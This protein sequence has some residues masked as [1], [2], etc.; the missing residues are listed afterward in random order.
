MKKL[1]IGLATGF[2]LINMVGI[3]SAIPVSLVEQGSEWNYTT[4]SDDLWGP[5]GASWSSV[6]YSSFDWDSTSASWDTGLAAFGNK[7]IYGGLTKNTFWQARTDLA[8][9]QSFIVDIAL[10]GDV[11]LNVASDNGF[12]IFINGTQVAK[13]NA[14]G[15]TSYWEYTYTASSI[16]NLLQAGEN[17]IQVLAEDHGGV[18]FFDLQLTTEFTPVPEPATM[19][20]FGIG[21]AGLAST[22]LRKKK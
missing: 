3:A 5:G 12:A 2:F 10:I 11:T 8:L 16:S 4:L 20:L 7:D 15:F 14:E 21:L 22:R 19:L 18:T 17:T 9:E 13:D 1:L 6:D